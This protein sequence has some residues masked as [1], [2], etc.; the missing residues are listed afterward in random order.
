MEAAW[1]GTFDES[2]PH[3]TATLLP[4]ILLGKTRQNST[5]GQKLP[6]GRMSGVFA[7]SRFENHNAGFASTRT[8]AESAPTR[9]LVKTP[10]RENLVNFQEYRDIPL[11]EPTATFV[12]IVN[13]Y[14]ASGDFA[15]FSSR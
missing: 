14:G 10:S 11:H 5:V 4:H 8:R 15:G 3:A 6:D 1:T 12:S 2:N 13:F 7:M 9:H